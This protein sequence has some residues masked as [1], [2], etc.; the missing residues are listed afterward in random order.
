MAN[1]VALPLVPGNLPSRA[2]DLGGAGLGL[3]LAAPLLLVAACAIR[4]TMGSPVLFRQTRTGLHERPFTLLKLRTMRNDRDADGKLLP[5]RQ[6]L[7]PV[8]RLLRSLSIDELP[9]LWNVLRGDMALVGPRPLYPEYLP[10]YTMRERLRHL[11][12]PGLTGLAQTSGRN[13]LHWDARLECDARYVET[14]SFALDV[15]ILL[16]TVLKVLARSD[17]RDAAIQGSLV[18]LRARNSSR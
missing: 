17:V 15:A 14:K 3:V 12:R 4:L 16:R 2:L 10:Y 13:S 7:T 1:E 9:Q 11:V 6:R 8:G 5:G 18:G